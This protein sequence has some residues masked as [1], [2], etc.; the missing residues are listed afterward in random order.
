MLSTFI[1]LPVSMPLG[2]F[3]LAG[4]N[5][6]GVDTALTKKDQKKLAK[7]MKLVDI[8]TSVLAV[9]KTSISK[10]LNDGR[11]DEQEFGMLQ[12]FYLGVLNKLANVD[13]KMEAETRTLLQKVYWK[14]L[15]I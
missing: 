6:N 9:F 1:G 10:V 12:T 5:I 4:A 11:A 2:A 13:P 8:V 3:S 14:R 7:V 15:T